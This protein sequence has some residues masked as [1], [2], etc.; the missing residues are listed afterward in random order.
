MILAPLT[1]RLK[2]HF[3][4]AALCFSDDA[5]ALRR[6]LLVGGLFECGERQEL[7]LSDRFKLAQALRACQAKGARIAEDPQIIVNNLIYGDDFLRRP[8]SGYDL[9][10]FSHIYF[11][12][13]PPRN[14]CNRPRCASQSSLAH[15]TGAW[16]RA[17]VR[18]DARFAVNVHVNKSELPTGL[19]ARAPYRG[20]GEAH[21]SRG[22]HFDVLQRV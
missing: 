19:L 20:I 8:G 15:E 17:L 11:S 5:A 6:V 10:V 22:F 3:E 21:I 1:D 4:K 13:E 18:S 2:S 12:P 7:A 9:V 16:H 14:R